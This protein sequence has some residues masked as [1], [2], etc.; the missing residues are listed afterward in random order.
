MDK[1]ELRDTSKTKQMKEIWPEVFKSVRVTGC[2][3]LA[4]VILVTQ[5]AEIR[6]IAVQNQPGQIVPRNPISKKPI[7]K[8]GLVK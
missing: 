5:E 8:I 3:W 1:Y 7:I 2:W 6:R 4:L